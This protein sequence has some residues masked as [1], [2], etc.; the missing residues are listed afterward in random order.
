M[1]MINN[2][3][4]IT[5]TVQ[6]FYDR[7]GIKETAK[8]TV[9]KQGLITFVYTVHTTELLSYDSL[10]SITQLFYL[11]MPVGAMHEVINVATDRKAKLIPNGISVEMSVN[12]M[13]VHPG[14][15]STDPE[16]TSVVSVIN[17]MGSEMLPDKK[18]NK[19]K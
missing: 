10:I 15:N 8:I 1:I 2:L 6:A 18:G 3:E 14:Q 12:P 4:Q 11:L 16:R 13:D 19:N 5:E 7:T 9:E 17:Q